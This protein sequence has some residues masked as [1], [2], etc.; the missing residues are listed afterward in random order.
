MVDSVCFYGIL[1]FVFD[2]IA[3]IIVHFLKYEKHTAEGVLIQ[4]IIE[5]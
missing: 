1:S 4:I 2:G 5:A 3:I